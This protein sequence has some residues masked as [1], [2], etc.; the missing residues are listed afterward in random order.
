MSLTTADF[1]RGDARH[2][3]TARAPAPSAANERASDASVR[4]CLR[5]GVRQQR[6]ARADVANAHERAAVDHQLRPAR[7]VAVKV[8]IARAV[9]RA[10]RHRLQALE[11]K[12]LSTCAL[13]SA[14]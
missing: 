4:M 7:A 14:S 6:H 10:C 3:T 5:G 8:R 2:T 1:W 11:R 12:R 9:L 13:Q